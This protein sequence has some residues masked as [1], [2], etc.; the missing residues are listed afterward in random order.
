MRAGWVA[1]TSSRTVADVAD[2]QMMSPVPLNDGG[3]RKERKDGR[4]KERRARNKQT[5][6]ERTAER[7]Y[8]TVL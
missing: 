2:V 6:K 3:R 5:E 8:G 1:Y 7:D 4:K